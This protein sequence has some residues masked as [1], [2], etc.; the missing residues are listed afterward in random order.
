MILQSKEGKIN[1]RTTT[2]ILESKDMSTCKTSNIGCGDYQFHV[3]INS[4]NIEI[5]LF[6]V[7]NFFQDI[8]IYF[9]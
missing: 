3:L 6:R 8:Q 7:F 9:Q 1:F 5:Y 4:E 2:N